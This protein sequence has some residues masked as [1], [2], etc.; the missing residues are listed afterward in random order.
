MLMEERVNSVTSVWR[1]DSDVLENMNVK[2]I[3]RYF[4]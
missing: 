3:N 2:H 4:T 1:T